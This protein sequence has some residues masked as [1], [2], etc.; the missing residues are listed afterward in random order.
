MA[1]IGRLIHVY[2]VYEH[3]SYCSKITLPISVLSY[4]ACSKP[5]I[6]KNIKDTSHANLLQ[7]KQTSV[8]YVYNKFNLYH[9]CYQCFIVLLT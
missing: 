2:K 1:T 8:I 7:H 6:A 3:T 5:K 9:I 4:L